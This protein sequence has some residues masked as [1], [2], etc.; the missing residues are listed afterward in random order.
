MS[1]LDYLDRCG[2]TE[3]GEV[4]F[5]PLTFT[6]EGEYRFTVRELT[7]S[8]ENWITD[9]R[10]YPVIVIVTRDDMG[11]LVAD[12]RYPE[13][14]PQFVNRYREKA[15]KAVH[16][17]LQSKKVVCGSR[18]EKHKFSFVVLDKS[19][20]VIARAQNDRDGNVKFPALTFKQA[21]VYHYI[22]RE[23]ARSNQGWVMDQNHY[24]IVVKVVEG[25][26][27]KLLAT[28]SYPK[29]LPVFVNHYAP[30]CNAL[31]VPGSGERIYLPQRGKDKCTKQKSPPEK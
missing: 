3:A 1:N 19:G 23:N 29:G 16:V 11:Q 5:P 21:G 24:P 15:H 18:V 13:G 8:D 14:A 20:K 30:K 26:E 17:H 6:H 4:H 2:D 31:C 22:V 7:E 12:V 25:K 27:G 9:P 10:V 28:V